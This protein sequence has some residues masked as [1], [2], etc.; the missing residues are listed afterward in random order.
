M[1]AAV[2]TLVQNARKIDPVY[3]A[4]IAL[5][6]AIGAFST[7]QLLDSLQFLAMAMISISPFL[8]LSMVAAGGDLL[9]LVCS[10]G[11]GEEHE[12]AVKGRLEPVGLVAS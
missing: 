9:L 5:L 11:H 3:L 10:H 1:T 4:L 6:V 12:A 8:L 7:T 2:G